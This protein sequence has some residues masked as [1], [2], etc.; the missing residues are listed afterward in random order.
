MYGS[1]SKIG[2]YF[3][4]LGVFK[5]EV[6]KNIFNKNCAHKLGLLLTQKIHFKSQI[7][8]F[9]DELSFI[10]FTKYNDFL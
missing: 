10:V 5:I 1:L 2:H 9:F 6:I 8:A 4:K 7:F 3:R